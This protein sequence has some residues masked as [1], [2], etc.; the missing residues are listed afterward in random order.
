MSLVLEGHSSAIQDIQDDTSIDSSLQTM[1]IGMEMNGHHGHHGHHGKYHIVFVD[2]LNLQ[3]TL[4]SPTAMISRHIENSVWYDANGKSFVF[5]SR[6]GRR[7]S[8][9]V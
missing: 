2:R 3:P 1:G 6:N 9:F 5:W 8:N 4:T 7:K